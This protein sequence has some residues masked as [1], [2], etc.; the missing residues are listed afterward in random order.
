MSNLQDLIDACEVVENDQMEP[1]DGVFDKRL[2]IMIKGYN[3]VALSGEFIPLRRLLTINRMTVLQWY[4]TGVV[5]LIRENEFELTD[6]MGVGIKV[7]NFDKKVKLAPGD[8]ILLKSAI[9]KQNLMVKKPDSIINIGRIEDKKCTK[10]YRL[11]LDT[12]CSFHFKKSLNES[13]NNRQSVKTTGNAYQFE[14]VRKKPKNPELLEKT[15]SDFFKY[16]AQKNDRTAKIIKKHSTKS[17]PKNFTNPFLEQTAF[18][19]KQK[20]M[21]EAKLAKKLKLSEDE[22]EIDFES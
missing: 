17:G 11:T 4:T 16:I 12:L 22:L 2:Q 6:M 19:K 5:Q 14:E 8:C 10:C 18:F 21:V 1:A 7:I 13:K 15:N 20:E 3:P 9:W